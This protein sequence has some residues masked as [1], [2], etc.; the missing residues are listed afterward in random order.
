[1]IEILKK[2]FAENAEKDAVP[3]VHRNI[4]FSLLVLLYYYV[5]NVIG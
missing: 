5:R 4:T 3:N 2:L 1:M